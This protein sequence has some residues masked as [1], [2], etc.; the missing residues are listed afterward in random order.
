MICGST[1]KRRATRAGILHL[2]RSATRIHWPHLNPLEKAFLKEFA[3]LGEGAFAWPFHHEGA[4]PRRCA[5]SK[6][7]SRGRFGSSPQ[8][9][10]R[11]PRSKAR[12]CFHR[13]RAAGAFLSLPSPIPDRLEASREHPPDLESVEPAGHTWGSRGAETDWRWPLRGLSRLGRGP[14]CLREEVAPLGPRPHRAV[15]VWPPSLRGLGKYP[16]SPVF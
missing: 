14:R 3:V 16:Q 12:G 15:P 5:A 1:R 7:S 8:G 4:D 2:Q 9:D 11:P 13:L 10:P 6:D